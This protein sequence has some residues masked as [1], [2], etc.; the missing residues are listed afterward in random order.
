MTS[1]SKPI[2]SGQRWQVPGIGNVIILKSLPSGER[3]RSGPGKGSNVVYAT[4][5]GMVG[6]CLKSDVYASGILLP[7]DKDAIQNA[8]NKI[9]RKS[10]IDNLLRLM[11]K[12]KEELN[13]F[14]SYSPPKGWVKKSGTRVTVVESDIES[15]NEEKIVDAEIIYPETSS[16]VVPLRRPFKTKA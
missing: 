1:N 14:P 15:G 4:D 11:E 6:Y 7:Y 5:A 3:F 10:E 13:I 2:L 8:I 16:N 9:K 12:K